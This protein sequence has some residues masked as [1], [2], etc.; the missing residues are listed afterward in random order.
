MARDRRHFLSGQR[1][2]PGAITGRRAPPTSSTRR[3]SRTTAR[4]CAKA[5]RLLV[6][7]MLADDTTVGAE[8]DRVR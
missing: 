7:R 8:P 4:G 5:A 6:E 3:S 1:I 2:N